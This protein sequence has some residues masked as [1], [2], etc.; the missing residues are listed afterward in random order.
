MT[1]LCAL[2]F[3]FYLLSILAV[4]EGAIN[5]PVSQETPIRLAKPRPKTSEAPSP[6]DSPPRDQQRNP[7]RLGIKEPPNGSFIGGTTVYVKLDLITHMS[8]DEFHTNYKDSKVCLSLDDSNYFCWPISSTI[9]FSNTVDGSHTLQAKL[10]QNG[11]LLDKSTSEVITF[12]TVSDPTMA[13]EDV[14]YHT[15]S[16]GWNTKLEDEIMDLD[17]T[18]DEEATDVSFPQIQLLTPMSRVSYSGTDISLDA[19]VE[20]VDPDVFNKF[21]G[22]AYTCFNIDMATAH[23]CFPLFQ[24]ENPMAVGLN[25]GFHTIETSLSNPE[26]GE[27]LEA[28]SSGTMVFFMA[29]D[30]NMGAAFTAEMNLRGKLHRIPVVMGGCISQQS[31]SLCR[32]IG[33]ENNDV[34]VA[35]VFEHLRMIASQVGFLTGSSGTTSYANEE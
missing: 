8:K 17:Q 24:E 26:T 1:A 6:R 16:P 15:Q 23:F 35:P 20:P 34:C 29:G 10:Y 21:F 33:L 4:G 9:M 14:E 31:K 2:N 5:A 11:Q 7:I 28:S 22:H 19:L 25:I 13:D 12:T 30:D 27:L 3:I 18:D 32:A